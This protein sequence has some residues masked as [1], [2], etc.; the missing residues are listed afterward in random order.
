MSVETV[1]LATSPDISVVPYALSPKIDILRRRAFEVLDLRS[2]PEPSRQKLTPARVLSLGNDFAQAVPLKRDAAYEAADVSRYQGVFF[3]GNR[4]LDEMIEL[5]WRREEKQE[6]IEQYLSHKIKKD[7]KFDG[8]TA[9]LETPG[10]HNYF[11]WMTELLPRFV[12]LQQ[13]KLHEQVDRIYVPLVVVPSFARASL[14]IIAPE[15]MEK[16]IFGADSSIRCEKA[17]FF[18]NDRTYR[19]THGTDTRFTESTALIS[20]RLDGI[21]KRFSTQPEDI[22]L[23]SRANAPTRKLVNE[24]ELVA[25]LSHRGIRVE[26]MESKSLWEQMRLMRNAKVVIGVHG[27]GLTNALYMQPN[28]HLIELTHA[29]YVARFRSFADIAMYRRIKY[30]MI[31]TDQVGDNATIVD[32]VGN[33]LYIDPA[34][35][36]E[37]DDLL[38]RLLAATDMEARRRAA[39]RADGSRPSGGA[40]PKAS[41]RP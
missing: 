25:A 13:S 18:I 6:R 17:M 3:I 4:P 9:I 15:L 16:V 31:L 28:T 30:T 38:G 8:R 34:R 14:R 22:L 36:G 19:A 2:R 35:L 40:A 10:M 41:P 24:A 23:I 26:T 27:A 1:S 21:L 39:A 20:D 32:N 33:D 7:K 29:Q 37:V 12:I 11:H 5:T